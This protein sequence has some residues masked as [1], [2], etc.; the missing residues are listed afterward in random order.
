M[1]GT[2]P[3]RAGK[4]HRRGADRQRRPGRRDGGAARRLAGFELPKHVAVVPELPRNA[5]GNVQKGLLHERYA[6]LFGG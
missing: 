1:D 4:R 5:M 2:A 6:R 3:D